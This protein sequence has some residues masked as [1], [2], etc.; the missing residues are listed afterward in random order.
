MRMK[1]GLLPQSWVWQVE[2]LV[3]RPLEGVW[4]RLEGF[5]HRLCRVVRAF[6]ALNSLN[7]KKVLDNL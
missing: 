7:L 5:Q 4:V 3:K 1:L 6:L 2:R